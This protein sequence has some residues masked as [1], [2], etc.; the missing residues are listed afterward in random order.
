[1]P[2]PMS[3]QSWV[4]SQHPP[5]QWNLRGGTGPKADFN[6]V[7][8]NPEWK[9]QKRLAGTWQTFCFKLEGT[10]IKSLTFLQI[11]KINKISFRSTKNLFHA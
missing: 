2:M 9:R 11:R 5:T 1:M 10:E 4:Q 7:Q 6:K 3:Q 8:K